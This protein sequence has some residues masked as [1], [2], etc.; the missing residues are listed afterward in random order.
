VSDPAGTRVTVAWH[1]LSVA[2]ALARLRSSTDG[3]DDADARSRLAECGPN[4]LPRG[5]PRAWWRILLDQVRSVVVALLAIAVALSLLAGDTIDATAVAAVLVLNA[6]LGFVTE[7]RARRSL[8]SLASLE[9]SRATVVRAGSARDIEATM[10]VPGDVIEVRAGDTVPADAR[11]L[12]ANEMTVVEAALTGES[13]PAVKEAAIEMAPDAA[14]A[15]RENMLYMATHVAAGS[16]RALV[17]ATGTR[18]EVGRIGTL[19]RAIPEE[20]TPLERRLDDLGGR[21]AVVALV[22]AVIVGGLAMLRELPL[23]EALR[24]AVA[25][26]VA[27]VPEALPAVATIALAVGAHRMVRRRALARRLTTVETLGSTTI[28]CTDKTGTLTAGEMTV[29]EMRLADRRFTVSGAGVHAPGVISHDNVPA[30]AASDAA[31][32]RALRVCVLANRAALPVARDGSARGD[33]TEVALLV[34]ARKGGLDQTGLQHDWPEVAEIPFSSERKLMASV[35]RAPSGQVV[36]FAKGAPVNVLR[37]CDR[38]L[39]ADGIIPVDEASSRAV[40]DANDEMAA[41]GLRVLALADGA[42]AEPDATA[43]TRLVFVGLVAMADPP[44]PGVRDVIRHIRDAGI[45]TL[46]ITGDQRLTAEAVASELEMLEE[47]VEVLE[48]REVE[49]MPD[50]TLASRVD[51]IGVVS[52]ST[53]EAKLRLVSALQRSGAVVAMLGDGINDAAALRKAD[54]G[55]AMGRRGTDVAKEAA[56]LVLLDDRFE[57]IAAA[58][59]EGRAI[60]DNIRKFVFYLVSCNLAE[61]LLLVGAGVLAL[62]LPLWPLQILWLN[63]VTDTFPALSL[64]LEPAEDDVMRRPPR[65]PSTP[66][67]PR[68]LL[69]AA[70]MDAALIAGVALAA[71][72][73]GLQRSADPARAV[74]MSFMTLALAQ[75]FHL[76]NARSGRHVVSPRRALANRWALGAVAISVALQLLAVWLEPLAQLLGVVAPTDSEWLVIVSLSALPAV[77]GQLTRWRAYRRG[78]RKQ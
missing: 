35:H 37:I 11:L 36:A 32:A 51:R 65:A 20:R 2:D 50:D 75:I 71:F 31:L 33:P 48:G 76:G 30:T 63:L 78:E 64:A 16:A 55:V 61:I 39:T 27:A 59:E 41:R 25:L 3:L 53:P 13:V 6:A 12:R 21:L 14:L 66:I 45:R 4:S 68:A 15:E 19:M 70:V 8:A 74:T 22:I 69:R 1:A 24:V 17:V 23:T 7:F 43:L 38:V 28:V 9:V 26:A 77:I 73:W 10:L 49:E 18:T 46:M 72:L 29:T 60:F 57:T 42:I 56:G 5:S 67:L 34:A 47:G 52:R 54:V 44:A 58:I 62:P 40:A